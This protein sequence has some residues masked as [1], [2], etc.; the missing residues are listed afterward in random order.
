MR[1]LIQIPTSVKIKTGYRTNLACPCTSKAVSPFLI[2]TNLGTNPRVIGR[3][4][5]PVP[6]YQEASDQT[7]K[8]RYWKEAKPRI[9]DVLRNMKSSPNADDFKR[10]MIQFS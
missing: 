2:G 10:W 9:D 3:T 5:T 6:S 7:L 8:S 1:V 4:G